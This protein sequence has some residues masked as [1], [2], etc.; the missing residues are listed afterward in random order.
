MDP[1]TRVRRRF[2]L[3]LRRGR[4]R[5]LGYRLIGQER[6]KGSGAGM[7]G[8]GTKGREGEVKKRVWDRRFKRGFWVRKGSGSG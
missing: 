2:L 5:E 3:T 1:G 6:V 8:D 4:R 7:V